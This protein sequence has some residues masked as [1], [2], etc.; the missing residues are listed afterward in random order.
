MDL[1]WFDLMMWIS[2]RFI[3]L[4]IACTQLHQYFVSIEQCVCEDHIFSTDLRSYPAGVPLQ[5]SY[6]WIT[7]H[8]THGISYLRIILSYFLFI[9][10]S[11]NTDK[12]R[13]P[14]KKLFNSQIHNQLCWYPIIS[15]FIAF[16]AIQWISFHYG[17]GYMFFFMSSYSFL[18]HHYMVGSRYKE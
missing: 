1:I 12:M 7:E 9:M 16:R 2:A 5:V 17:S 15:L 11:I 4:A 18:S 6:S 10:I 3:F 8:S 14:S 13:I